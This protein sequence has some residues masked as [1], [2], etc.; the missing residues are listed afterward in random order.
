MLYSLARPLLF[1]LSGEQAHDL[2]LGLLRHGGGKLWPARVPDR[3]RTVMGIEFP[4]PVG[5]AAGLDKNADC[6]DGLAELGFGFIEVGTVT[7]RPQPGNPVPRL[8]R[9][10]QAQALINRMGFNNKGVAHLVQTV[11]RSRY[12]GVLGI[13]IGKNKDTPVEQAVDDYLFCQQRVHAHASYLVVN[14]SSPNTPGLRTLQ[15]GDALN[16]LLGTLRESQTRL[17]QQL[18]RRVPLV[19]K[20]AP[21]SSTE[22]LQS[23][24]QA[25]IE[26]GIDGV[27]VGNTTLSREGVT[28]FR[29]G[30][31]TGGLSGAPL[32]SIADHALRTMSQALNGR[33]PLIGVGGI[34]EADDALKK[35]QL[36]AELVQVYSG[37]VYRGPGL[38]GEIA[39]AW[40]LG[41]TAATSK[42]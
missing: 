26:H 21:D 3:P 11:K 24:A 2:T 16:T 39:R 8:F 25:F 27:C 37:L 10:P 34:M 19:V 32:K 36:G 4:N 5:L 17:D 6:I 35:Q 14:V 1:T 41:K 31:E 15:H 23:M 22:E 28:G 29:H 42:S 40:P 20:I 33:I 18:G 38:V 9:V 13:N 30:D 12:Q 7:P